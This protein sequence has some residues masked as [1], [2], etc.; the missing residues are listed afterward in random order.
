M[1]LRIDESARNI[2]GRRLL[3]RAER[4]TATVPAHRTLPHE[5]PR[6]HVDAWYARSG[7]ALGVTFFDWH[8]LAV[9]DVINAL[10]ADA[11]LDGPLARL[12]IARADAGLSLEDLLTDLDGLLAII[13]RRAR[14][15]LDRVAFAIAPT[16]GWSE[17]FTERL[18]TTSCIDPMSGLVNGEFLEVRANQL[19][20]QCAALGIPISQAFGLV[21][22]HFSDPTATPLDRMH[23]S[24]AIA[25]L[26]RRT[27]T[28]G[29]TIATT[30]PWCQVAVASRDGELSGR[31]A[32]LLGAFEDRP[33]LRGLDPRLWVEPLPDDIDTLPLLL[34]DLIAKPRTG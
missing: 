21:V 12:G 24:A 16:A 15:R 3:P 8:R 20:Q 27:F 5:A 17:A 13:P 29:E 14:R 34:D 6:E 18:T 22:V 31:L 25:S 26:L 28:N 33:A 30:A 4:L 32:A 10:L 1:K 19:H 23:H 7:P 9:D 11:E 2:P